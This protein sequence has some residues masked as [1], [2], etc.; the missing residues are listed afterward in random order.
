M[1]LQLDVIYQILCY[2]QTT[3]GFQ[4]CVFLFIFYIIDLKYP[5]MWRKCTV[6][7]QIVLSILS[8]YVVYYKQRNTVRHDDIISCRAGILPDRNLKLENISQASWLTL[9]WMTR[10]SQSLR[11][12]RD[13]VCE[14]YF[15]EWQLRKGWIVLR[16]CTHVWAF[17]VQITKERRAAV[18]TCEM[19]NSQII[20]HIYWH[21]YLCIYVV[22]L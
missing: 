8:T 3:S 2:I 12:H 16:S 17:E 6:F 9:F 7:K 4:S 15:L 11:S 18:S 22:F 14:K 21:W 1:F 5:N 10:V 19:P 13:D 20:R